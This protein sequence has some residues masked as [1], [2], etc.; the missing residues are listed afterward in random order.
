MK[1]ENKIVMVTGAS[2]GIGSA[3]A[4][5]MSRAGAAQVLLL[6]RNEGGLRKV[7]GEIEAGGGKACL[8]TVDL[9]DSAAVEN[10]AQRILSK[11]GVPD[12]LVNNAGSGKWRFLQE[13]DAE[14]I[15]QVMA[16]PYFAAAW[17]T[18]RFLPGMLK[19][20]SG[21]VVNISSVASRMAWPGA[22]AY[23]VACR[24]MRGFSDALR[25]DLYGTGIGVT[26]YESGPIDSPYWQNNPGS[27]ER[28]PGVARL[29]LPVLTEVRVAHAVVD[30]VEKS[31]HFVVV[32][33]ML[34]FVYLLHFAFPWLVQWLMTRTGYH[35]AQTTDA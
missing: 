17:I 35:P 13:T 18:R 1:I 27:R 15:V 28:V 14:E 23:I 7:A 29:L 26:H 22:T 6:A 24:A 2:S 16:L 30:G 5:A 31:K 8:Y 12:I 4:R 21:H 34:R 19:R 9:S 32:P 25:A 3:I 20:G 33:G 10:V 11:V